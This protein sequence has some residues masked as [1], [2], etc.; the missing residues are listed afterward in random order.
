VPTQYLQ[1]RFRDGDHEPGVAPEQYRA[2]FFHG[3]GLFTERWAH[4]NDNGLAASSE[5]LEVYFDGIWDTLGTR[6]ATDRPLMVLCRGDVKLGGTPHRDESMLN[7]G[8]FVTCPQQCRLGFEAH[9]RQ[10]FP[11]LSHSGM[12]PAHANGSHNPCRSG[13][14]SAER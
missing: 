9:A 14:V 11:A 1:S 6:R 2:G 12:E 3:A 4:K 10:T 8:S 5:D 13:D 7:P